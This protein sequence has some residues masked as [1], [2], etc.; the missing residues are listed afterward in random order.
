MER[1]FGGTDKILLDSAGQG[2]GGNAGGVV[3]ILPLNELLRRA[4]ETG[5]TGGTR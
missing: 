3:P 5:T 4:P 2:S 1:V